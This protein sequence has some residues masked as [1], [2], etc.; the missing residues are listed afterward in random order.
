MIRVSFDEILMETTYLGK[1]AYY[2]DITGFD[3]R[4]AYNLYEEYFSIFDRMRIA[5]A[6]GS[7][8]KKYGYPYVSCLEFSRRELQEMFLK[9]FRWEGLSGTAER[10]MDNYVYVQDMVR[11]LL[12]RERFAEV[13]QIDLDEEY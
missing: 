13:M 6:S 3:V 10:E 4:P 7:Y 8:Q 2:G 5:M 11:S 9:D 12:W 1:K